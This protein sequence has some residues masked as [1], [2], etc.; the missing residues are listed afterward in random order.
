[1]RPS[2][3]TSGVLLAVTGLSVTLLT[4]SPASPAGA[5]SCLPTPGILSA[6]P[7]ASYSLPG[8]ASVRIWDTNLRSFTEKDRRLAVVRI[9]KGSLTPTVVTAPTVSRAAKPSTMVAGDPK[10][11]V[12]VNGGTFNPTVPGIPDRVQISNGVVRKLVRQAYSNGLYGGIAVDSANKTITGA[13]FDLAGSFSTP[14][15]SSIVGGVNWQN[16]T[17]Q[18]VSVYTY[19]WGSR[20]HPAGTRAV[21]VAGTKVT[22]ILTGSAA[23]GRPATWEKYVTA[24]PGTAAASLLAKVKV[25]DTATLWYGANGTTRYAGYPATAFSKP[26]GATGSGGAIVKDGAI[27]APC[28]AR[29]E[30]PRPRSAIAFDAAGNMLVVAVA[31]KRA[32]S[33]WGGVSVHQFAGLLKQLGAVTA[34]RLDGGTSTTLWVRKTVGGPLVRLDRSSAD[35][36]REVVDALSFRAL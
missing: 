10:A 14:A 4:T 19:A 25:G 18:G 20:S 2:A 36:E 5:V 3:R 8:G 7:A 32:G 21:V 23:T 17:S 16:L 15:G 24:A 9:P 12:V 13:A 1:M 27:V 31:G 29:D 35:Y 26:S 11:V 6:A 34:I 22:K 33:S 28:S 30:E